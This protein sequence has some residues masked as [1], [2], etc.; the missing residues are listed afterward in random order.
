M[1]RAQRTT[2]GAVT[3]RQSGRNS[4]PLSGRR[5]GLLTAF[6]SNAGGG[7][8]QVVRDQAAKIRAM[9]GEAVVFALDDGHG[10]AVAAEFDPASLILARIAGPRQIGYAPDQLRQLHEA[11]LDLLHLH[12]IWMHP[13][14]A[15]SQ[16]AHETGRPY[17]ISPHGMLDPWITARGRWKKALA[18]L[19][20]ERTGWARATALHALTAREARDIADETGRRDSLVIPNA[21][22][23]CG[24]MP[25]ALRAPEVLYLG[26]IHPKK[27]LAGLVAGWRL[28]R[29]PD[30]ARLH[31]AGWGDDADV[32][33]LRHLLET[34]N[35]DSIL[36]HGPTFGEAKQRLLKAARFLILPSFSE[37][38]PMVVLEAWAA[39]TPALTSE[40]CNLPEGFAANAALLCETTPEAIARVLE[41]GL[42]LD[43][44]AWLAMAAAA[45]SLAAGPFSEAAISHRWETAYAGLLAGERAA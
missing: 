26:R 24:A 42:S 41:Q 12:G 1:A 22:P 20:Y 35:D 19:G 33:D 29:R 21:A 32:A 39:A 13:S 34:A 4:G 45:R 2:A 8:A 36:F 27:N 3:L 6:A 11:N 14:R 5:I 25:G 9:G 31:I 7:V 43:E 44:P 18:R 23:A 16:W 38:L 30:G 10:P 15:G 28:A 37:G 40:G 17:M